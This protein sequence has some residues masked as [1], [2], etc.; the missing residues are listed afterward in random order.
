MLGFTVGSISLKVFQLVCFVHLVSANC[1]DL[2]SGTLYLQP[3]L[4][5]RLPMDGGLLC[6]ATA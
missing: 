4:A 3:A 1:Y 6:V 2:L 5:L